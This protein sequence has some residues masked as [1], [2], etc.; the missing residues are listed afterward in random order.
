MPR[1]YPATNSN[2]LYPYSS[3]LK[4][5]K[6]K[7]RHSIR[8]PWI[9]HL[10]LQ[11]GWL[12]VFNLQPSIPITHV[13]AHSQIKDRRNIPKPV[14]KYDFISSPFIHPM[15]R[16]VELCVPLQLCYHTL[17]TSMHVCPK[18]LFQKA[19]AWLSELTKD[20]GCKWK[21]VLHPYTNA[22]TIQWIDQT[23]RLRVTVCLW[24]T[25]M[26]WIGCVRQCWVL[27]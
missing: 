2:L 26:C 25:R 14:L 23:H 24:V 15:R 22:S 9:L 1:S 17:F 21:S 13:F 11:C 18:Q 19:Y 3:V 4:T 27:E 10:C 8:L 6:L 7:T 20:T 5:T 12:E 16:S